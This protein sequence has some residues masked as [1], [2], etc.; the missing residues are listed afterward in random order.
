MTSEKL[1]VAIH[2]PSFFPWLGFFDKILKSDIFVILDNVQFPKTGGFW[3]NRVKILVSGEPAW[4]TMP[5]VRSYS[6]LRDINQMEINNLTP[7]REKL[8]KTIS[9][10]YKK[11]PFYN[12]VFSILESLI[13][14]ETNHLLE[15]N[16]NV[17]NSLCKILNIDNSNTILASSL[18]PKGK[19]TDLLISIV[20]SLGGSEYICGGGADKY[21]ENEKFEQTGIKLTYQN[22]KQPV[23]KQFNTK[24]FVS[25]LS[26]IDVLMNCGIEETQQIL[27]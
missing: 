11:A 21:Q 7:W 13:L 16:L 22:F 9:I 17:I 14:F 1:S 25:G 27:K 24:E 2:Q 18:T 15:Y 3:A 23:Y 20:T 26:V 8:I 6:G 19:A 12:E 5:I 10:N 4:I